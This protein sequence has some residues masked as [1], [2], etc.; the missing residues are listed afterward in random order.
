MYEWK[1][2]NKERIY[3]MKK[4][5]ALICIIIIF[6]CGFVGC[7]DIKEN[8]A[9]VKQRENMEKL[10][11]EQQRQIG[12]PVIDNFFE[13]KMFKKIYE[14]R[15]NADLICYAYTRNLEGKYIFEGKCVGYGLPYSVQYYNPEKVVDAEEYLGYGLIDEPIAVIGQPE[16]NGMHMPEGLSATWI[17]RIDEDGKLVPDYY[18]PN[19]VVTTNK[20]P[21][22]L[23][24]EWS[25][26]EDY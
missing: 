25:L 1:L 7:K 18:E 6:I 15:D 4:L 3:F 20:K 21:A 2:L 11:E 10:Q 14:L 13:K 8:T 26:P 12:D 22:R 5:I 9:E 17:I 19:L 24:A 23:C 16:P